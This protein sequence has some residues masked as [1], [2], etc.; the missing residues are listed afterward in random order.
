M[1]FLVSP[2]H[3]CFPLL[4]VLPGEDR[5]CVPSVVLLCDLVVSKAPEDSAE[6][7]TGCCSGRVG[8]VALPTTSLGPKVL[9]PGQ[10]PTGLAS[11]A[12]PPSS[13]AR[14]A[15]LSPTCCRDI[16][17]GASL[18]PAPEQVPAPQADPLLTR[19]QQAC[20]RASPVPCARTQCP[21]GRGGGYH[22]EGQ[23]LLGKSQARCW[24][25]GAL[26]SGIAT[27]KE[28]TPVGLWS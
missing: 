13:T 16:P 2:W 18:S 28:V 12:Q 6:P 1:C 17:L 27:E 25:R 26:P 19:P 4:L 22:P 9:V 11:P 15:F 23:D 10:G 14:T 20:R 8:P 24:E 21:S 5:R 7:R 3:P